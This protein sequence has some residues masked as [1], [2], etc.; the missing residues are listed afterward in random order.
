[1][2]SLLSALLANRVN[3]AASIKRHGARFAAYGAAGIVVLTAA[4]FGV[5]GCY[6][7]IEAW[8]DPVRAPLFLAGGLLVVAAAILVAIGLAAGEGGEVA[9]KARDALDSDDLVDDVATLARNL[10]VELG[11]KVSPL[12]AAGIALAAGFLYGRR[13]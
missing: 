1:M 8:S 7:L 12:T 13:R 3:P 10:G 9:D 5:T 6:R 11:G 2:A 4:G